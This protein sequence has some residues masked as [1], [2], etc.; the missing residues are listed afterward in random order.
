MAIEACGK[1]KFMDTSK[2]HS[3]FPTTRWTLILSARDGN[4]AEARV[5]LEELCKMYWH[6]LFRFTR[7]IGHNDPDARDLTQ[8]FFAYL[9]PRKLFFSADP[10]RGRFRTF[11]LTAFKRYISDVQDREAAQK[12]GGGIEFVPL[13]PQDS[14]NPISHEPTASTPESEYDKAWAFTTLRAA[15]DRLSAHEI[16]AGRGEQFRELEPLLMPE[17]G[18]S[19][20]YAKAEELLG[21]KQPALRMIVLRLRE[22]F[23]RFLRQQIAETLLDP[24]DAQLEGEIAALKAALRS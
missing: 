7:R 12:R 20:G 10:E 19:A 17:R 6:P 9:L 1:F 21:K 22:K 11:L 2:T 16:Q 24:T 3:K 4:E 23:S 5:A 8:G 15:M 14:G 18:E 13:Y